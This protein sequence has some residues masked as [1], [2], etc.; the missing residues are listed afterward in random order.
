MANFSMENV[1]LGQLLNQSAD[2]Q[3][4]LY[5]LEFTGGKKSEIGE[6]NTNLS[7]R[8]SKFNWSMPEQESYQVK[9]LTAKIDRP[10]AKVKLDRKF[11][12][13]IRVDANYEIY[14]KLLKQEKLT[15]SPEENWATNDIKKAYDEAKLFDLKVKVIVGSINSST[16]TEKD[17]CAFEGCYITEIK[18]LAYKQDSTDPLVVEVSCNYLY[19]RD[20]FNKG[21]GT[22]DFIGSST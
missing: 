8:T 14:K 2:A 3:G 5:L 1:Y 9:F 22:Y 19:L 6:G 4:N 11:T 20:V 16:I 13:G 7:V 18:P 17:L 12:F 21:V 10:K 15:F